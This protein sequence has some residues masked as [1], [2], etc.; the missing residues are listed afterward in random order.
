MGA[1]GASVSDIFPA[2]QAL[3]PFFHYFHLSLFF[4]PLLLLH[5]FPF[6]LSPFEPGLG[7]I[8]TS[9]IDGYAGPCCLYFFHKIV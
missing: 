7:Y 8:Q 1:V 6:P 2:L 4:C 9:M 5:S 3:L